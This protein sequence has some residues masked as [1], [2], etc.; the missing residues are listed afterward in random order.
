MFQIKRK[1]RSYFKYLS[2]AR[3][4]LKSKPRKD[5]W[6]DKSTFFTGRTV[7]CPNDSF[8]N[9][10]NYSSDEINS[11]CS[12]PLSNEQLYGSRETDDEKLLSKS[13]VLVENNKSDEERSLSPILSGI[14]SSNERYHTKDK[15]QSSLAITGFTENTLAKSSDCE[16][17]E[18]IPSTSPILGTSTPKKIGANSDVRS[19]SEFPNFEDLSLEMNKKS[20]ATYKKVKATRKRRSELVFTKLVGKSLIEDSDLEI[21]EEPSTSSAPRHLSE[22]EISI[23]IEEDDIEFQ[24]MPKKKML[25]ESTPSS[26]RI[27]KK[28]SK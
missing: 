5:Y 7:R 13:A 6:I 22:N 14:K 28:L 11:K 24:E 25:K 20:V 10:E 1:K 21:V 3:Q 8:C 12:D 16:E 17:D 19:P 18:D 2:F 27:P 23:C 15:L 26:K 9:I 4:R